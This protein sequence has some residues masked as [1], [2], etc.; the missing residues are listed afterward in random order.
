MTV[1]LGEATRWQIER[2]W[3]RFYGEVDEGGK[4]KTRFL[5]RLQQ[6]G[7]VGVE[8]GQTRGEEVRRSTSAAALQGLFLYNKG[9]PEGAL[10]MAQGLLPD[11]VPVKSND[12]DRH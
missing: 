10:T 3:D 6:L 9:D 1:R 4:I 8:G 5:Q 11:E 2:L 12:E 7:I